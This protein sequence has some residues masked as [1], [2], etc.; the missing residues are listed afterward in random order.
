MKHKTS[1]DYNFN[2]ETCRDFVRKY[3]HFNLY[4]FQFQKGTY[5]S[6]IMNQS[7]QSRHKELCHQILQKLLSK[8]KIGTEKYGKHFK[9]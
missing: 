4:N 9:L 6:L 3:K 7:M 8:L 1:N 5:K 2:V